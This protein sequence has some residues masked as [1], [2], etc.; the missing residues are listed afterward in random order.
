LALKRFDIRRDRDGL[1]VFEVLITSAIRPRQEL[2]DRPVVG[3][4]GVRV[5][6]RDRKKLE[7]L[8]AGGW[9]GAGDECGG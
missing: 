7:E 8:F 1:D 2:L 9:P 6:D 4:S 5:A 3:S